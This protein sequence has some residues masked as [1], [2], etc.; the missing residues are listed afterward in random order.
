MEEYNLKIRRNFLNSKVN[1]P[2]E[3]ELMNNLN[4]MAL[5]LNKLN[6]K[7]SQEKAITEIYDWYKSKIVST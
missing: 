3:S 6:D 2:Y 4:Y 7:E 1:D 5:E